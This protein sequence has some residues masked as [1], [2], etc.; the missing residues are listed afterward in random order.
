MGVIIPPEKPSYTWWMRLMIASQKKKLGKPLQP[1]LYWGRH[2][3]AFF[4]FLWMLMAFNRKKSPLDKS[5]RAL[6]RVHISQL[7]HCSFC[8]DMNMSDAIKLGLSQEKLEALSVYK[9]NP[10]YSD[11]EKL[12]LSYAEAVVHSDKTFGSECQRELKKFLNDDAIIELTG[13]ITHQAMSA[14]FNSALGIEPHGFC[15]TRGPHEQA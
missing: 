3:R 12:I 10:L 11:K 2:P 13:L 1:I 9:N 5:W 15:Q 8:I 14:M 7:L 4:G 6:V